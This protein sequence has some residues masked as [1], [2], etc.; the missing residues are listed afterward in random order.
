LV[1]SVRVYDDFSAESK[2]LFDACHEGAGKP[3][4][5]LKRQN[6]I[7]AVA[8]CD[9]RRAVCTATTESKPVTDWGRSAKARG[10]ISASFKQGIWIMSFLFCCGIQP[11]H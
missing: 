3:F 10:R 2:R 8:A 9:I 1:V 4:I 7:N 11:D 6:M 5:V